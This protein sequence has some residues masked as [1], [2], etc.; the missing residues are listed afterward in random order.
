M[1]FSTTIFIYQYKYLNSN[2]I[3]FDRHNKY[4]I[5]TDPNELP[6]DE[7]KKIPGVIDIIQYGGDF[8]PKSYIRR[9]S[10]DDIG[11]FEFTIYGPE[12][13][14]FFNINIVEGRNIYEE[15]KMHS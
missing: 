2:Y 15:K 5:F 4:S 12:F 3:G 14:E 13:V 7:I 10:S 6:I 11:L 1:M 9:I 8:L